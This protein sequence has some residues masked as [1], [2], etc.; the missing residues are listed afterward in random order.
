MKGLLVCNWQVFLCS[1]CKIWR[2]PGTAVKGIENGDGS[3]PGTIAGIKTTFLRQTG[4]GFIFGLSPTI[5][6]PAEG[7]KKAR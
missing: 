5:R 6:Q 2:H 1:T 3:S 4:K 7:R